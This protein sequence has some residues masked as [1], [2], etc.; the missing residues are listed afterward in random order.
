[1]WFI[2]R[3][4]TR[5]SA[6]RFPGI[7]LATVLIATT[8]PALAA[9]DVVD[10]VA[11]SILSLPVRPGPE[12]IVTSGVPHIQLDQTSSV[13]IHDELAMW[14]FSLPTVV[15][16]PTAAS[17][18]G[19]RALTLADE[20]IAN[21]EA[22]I[23]GREFAHIHAD[24]GAG[25]LHLR[26]PLD[27]AGEAIGAGWGV[28]HPFSL[29]GSMPGLIMVYAPRDAADLEAIK[30]IIHASIAHATAQVGQD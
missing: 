7:V 3:L 28:W 23:V 19:A 18:P 11:D 5:W 4:P 9:D 27:V 22:M 14:A 13:E 21:D 10:D 6:R 17:L 26:L 25:S 8:A 30:L 24:P 15:E 16:R 29:D 2:S 20:V 12:P 1:M